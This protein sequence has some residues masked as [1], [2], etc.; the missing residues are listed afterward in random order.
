MKSKHV[1]LA[2]M[3]CWCFL[4]AYIVAQELPWPRDP[5]GVEYRVESSYGPRYL[6]YKDGKPISGTFF[7]KGID[8]NG[9]NLADSNGDK[10]YPIYAAA[11]GDIF[12]IGKASNGLKW[13]G[14]DYGSGRTFAYLHIFP[15]EEANS[16][17]NFIGISANAEIQSYRR[18]YTDN[19]I[20]ANEGV[21]L[22]YSGLGN[23]G[24]IVKALGIKGIH[25]KAIRVAAVCTDQ[26]TKNCDTQ[27]YPAGT[28]T[29]SSDTEVVSA[30]DGVLETIPQG[31]D[32]CPVC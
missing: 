4:P 5:H 22:F 15:N 32:K 10:N 25:A 19:N 7:H 24:R 13:I 12:G 31:D 29:D 23:A 27:I 26:V 1:L 2:G 20:F 18:I 30:G 8:L 17:G 14:I 28:P 3:V 9:R 16:K 11:Y 21:V 6:G